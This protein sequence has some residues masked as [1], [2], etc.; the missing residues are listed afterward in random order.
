MNVIK[1]RNPYN[2]VVWGAGNW[3]LLVGG[4]SVAHGQAK[5][6]L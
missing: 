5:A 4:D 1:N 2:E 6:I 3:E